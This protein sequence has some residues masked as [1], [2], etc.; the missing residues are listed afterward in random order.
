MRGI[1]GR[2]FSPRGLFLDEGKLGT[3]WHLSGLLFYW[4]AAVG[5]DKI[6][7]SISH[8]SDSVHFSRKLEQGLVIEQEQEESSP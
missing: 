6:N 1:C 4:P 2:D 5:V 3:K 7:H 8:R